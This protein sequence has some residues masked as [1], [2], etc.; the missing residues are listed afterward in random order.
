MRLAL[1]A[2]ATLALAAPALAQPALKPVLAPL[3]FLVGDWKSDAGKVADTGGTSAGTSHITVESDG[4]S[5]L[6]RDRT[7]LT[8]A[9]GKP[10]GGFSQVMLIYTEAGGLRADYS[11][12][13]GHVI[14]YQQ[15]KVR[16]GRSVTFMSPSDEGQ[17]AYRLEYE[18]KAPD[19]L[20]VTFGMLPQGTSTLHTIATGVLHRVK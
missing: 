12:G 13:E 7:D 5:L 8:G 18:L 11:D 16:P 14:H 17:P 3:G 4:W 20:A 2:L 9:D 19:T 1:V 15:A 6:R 10:A